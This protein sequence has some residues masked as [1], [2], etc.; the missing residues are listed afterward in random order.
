MP[1]A[2]KPSTAVQPD[3]VQV[4]GRKLSL[5]ET[6]DMLAGLIQRAVEL[7]GC[8][9]AEEFQRLPKSEQNAFI[10]QAS[11]EKRT[12]M[13]SDEERK[14]LHPRQI[15]ASP[16]N[17]KHFD[18]DKER[19][20]L[21]SVREH[22]ILQDILV[23]PYRP[24]T[25]VGKILL[26]QAQSRG[27]AVY[28]LVAGERRWRAATE[29]GAMVP[30]KIRELSDVQAIELQGIENL[31]REDLN[32]IEEAEKYHQLLEIYAK[33][34]ISQGDAIARICE[35]MQ[36]SRSS[37]Y[38]ALR[39]LKLP[40]IARDAAMA[41]RLPASHAGEIAKLEHA[42]G[43]QAEVV[44]QILK[45]KGA[46]F[47]DE[48]TEE[49]GILSFRATKAL[50]S[51]RLK[52]LENRK[53]W[54]TERQIAEKRGDTILTEEE[55]AAIVNS[56]RADE[57]SSHGF[58][59]MHAARSK[60]VIADMTCEL[61]GANWRHYGKLWKKPPQGVLVILRSGLPGYVFEKSIAD[62]AVKE[63]GKLKLVNGRASS[64]PASEI[65]AERKLKARRIVFASAIDQLVN[66]ETRR[67]ETDGYWM[68]HVR[69]LAK[70]L[71]SAARKKLYA[72][73][74]WEKAAEIS[75]IILDY[76]AADLRALAMEMLLH[77]TSS[78]HANSDDWGE[79]VVAVGKLYG[80]PLDDMLES[81]QASGHTTKQ[82]GKGNK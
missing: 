61:P 37:V 65:E 52:F 16:W 47:I 75:D 70:A 66:Q 46:G 27:E 56:N 38:T 53:E 54:E 67:P 82:D 11:G 49:N 55:S 48:D 79:G 2:Q 59:I 63:G 62:K 3:R 76:T 80:L 12:G 40:E 18:P 1:I 81:V 4:N 34:G 19:E 73:R 6:S 77:H 72:R 35:R 13:R 32:A 41:G 21:A 28:E 42:P 17:R 50:V 68:Q 15:V 24:E 7:A 31:I 64:R 44:C 51:E 25:I 20:L 58:W 36:R 22:G 26:E 14:L 74:G 43:I 39:L 5:Q 23:R 69:L 10:A 60:Y 71:H 33:E 30:A 45:P 8:G 29:V 78:P 57:Q 9:S